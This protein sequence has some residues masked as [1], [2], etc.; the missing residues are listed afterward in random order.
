MPATDE[1]ASAHR[2][3]RDRITLESCKTML[4]EL[5]KIPS[6]QTVLMEDE[7]LLKRFISGEVEPRLRKMGFSDIQYDAMGN[8]YSAHGAGTS[9]RSLMLITNAMNQPQ[10]TMTRAYEATWPAVS[11]TVCRAKW[12]WA[13]ARASRSE[14]GGDVRRDGE[15]RRV[16]HSTHRSPRASVLPFGRNRKAR[17]HQKPRRCDGCHGGDGISWRHQPKT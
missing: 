9:G 2:R 1:G 5:V 10:A 15:R 4:I 8:L 3:V 6:P 16:G 11:P 13:K 12:C 17:R 14:H 7:P